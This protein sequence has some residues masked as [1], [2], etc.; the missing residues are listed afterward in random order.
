M[1][2]AARL[3]STTVARTRDTKMGGFYMPRDGVSAPENAS[4][5]AV[6]RRNHGHVEIRPEFV[7]ESRSIGPPPLL[8]FKL[9]GTRGHAS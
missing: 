3:V 9:R 7:S 1:N 6:L 4:L 8:E 5:V 2:W